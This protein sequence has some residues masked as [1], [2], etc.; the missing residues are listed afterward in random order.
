MIYTNISRT[1]FINFT[2]NV[3]LLLGRFTDNHIK[4]SM[5]SL[6]STFDSTF[7][8]SNGS[9]IF[10]HLK[11]NAILVKCQRTVKSI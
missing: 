4:F 8:S 5:T 2:D 9:L 10:L 7:L 11:C 3:Y 1:S 6:F